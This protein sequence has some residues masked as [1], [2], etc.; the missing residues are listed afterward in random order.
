MG[1]NYK[2]AIVPSSG[3]PPHH[4]KDGPSATDPS[5]PL[6]QFQIQ[7]LFIPSTE[8]ADGYANQFIVQPVIPFK[9]MGW[10]FLANNPNSIGAKDSTVQDSGHL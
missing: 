2:L 9:K 1:P 6:L 4:G 10:S 3:T 8:H 7:N 5:A